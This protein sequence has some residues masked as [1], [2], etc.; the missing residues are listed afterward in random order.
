MFSLDQLKRFGGATYASG[1]NNRR[2]PFG[3]VLT[4]A[5]FLNE[6]SPGATVVR[7]LERE[8]RAGN[9]CSYSFCIPTSASEN[10]GPPCRSDRMKHSQL[11]RPPFHFQSIASYLNQHE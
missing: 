6:L 2:N 9:P 4:A 10:T 3:S 7:M 8:A 1:L 5:I 11:G